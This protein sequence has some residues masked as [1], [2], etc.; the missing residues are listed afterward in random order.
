MHE[1]LCIDDIMR[2]VF[3]FVDEHEYDSTQGL[4]VRQEHSLRM[5]AALSRTCHTF[6]DPALDVLWREIPDLYVL[7]KSHIPSHFLEI[8]KSNL[9]RMFQLFHK[10]P[11]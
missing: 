9:V 4:Y 5:L 1:C 3:G 6:K 8:K 11:R 2:V 10:E 7:I